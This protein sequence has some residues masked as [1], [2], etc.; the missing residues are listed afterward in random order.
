MYV[1]GVPIHWQG[2]Y[3]NTRLRKAELPTYPFQR[4]R[5]WIDEPSD[6]SYFRTNGSGQTWPGHPLLGEEM[7]LAENDRA[8]FTARLNASNPA[9]LKDHCVYDHIVFPATGYI[10]ILLASAKRILHTERITLEKLSIPQAM[11]LS[12]NKSVF[13]QTCLNQ[14][15]RQ[16]YTAGIYRLKEDQ[17]KKDWTL[18]ASCMVRPN[19][20]QKADFIWTSLQVL[21]ASCK[22]L[23]KG[24][25]RFTRQEG[26][27]P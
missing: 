10:E 13:V 4:R 6:P 24:R 18:H 26:E 21:Q 27:K 2:V 1:K 7:L 5:Y 12:E 22:D 3:N 20:Q 16:H 14:K 9:F 25:P 8:V 17:E 23:P 19:E 15:G 11:V